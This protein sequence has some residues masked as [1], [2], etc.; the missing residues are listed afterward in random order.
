ML[1]LSITAHITEMDGN[2]FEY[3]NLSIKNK[4]E[5]NIFN[6]RINSL[7]MITNLV[8]FIKSNETID[9][10]QSNAGSSSMYFMG[11]ILVISTST[12][13]NNIISNDDT[14]QFYLNEIELKQFKKEFYKL[15]SIYYTRKIWNWYKKS[16]KTKIL[17]KIAEYYTQKK[18]SPDNIMKYID[19][20]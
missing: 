18:Y 1:T 6:K 3:F 12:G 17:W 13:Y 5:N 8:S 20:E 11:N 2:E 14:S 19:F 15:N 9:F 4:Y 10:G 7:Y 16:K